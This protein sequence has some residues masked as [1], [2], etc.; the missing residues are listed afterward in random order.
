MRVLNRRWR[1]GAA[2]ALLIAVKRIPP[3]TIVPAASEFPISNLIANPPLPEGRFRDSKQEMRLY[4]TISHK[5]QT[6][7][8]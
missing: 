4:T 2:K 5:Q 8:H 7:E 6:D 1:I 3:A